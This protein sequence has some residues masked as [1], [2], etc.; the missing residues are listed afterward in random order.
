MNDLKNLNEIVRKNAVSYDNIK[1]H[2]KQRVTPSLENTVK[3][4]SSPGLF[5]VKHLVYITCKRMFLKR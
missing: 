1:S 5:R 2:K 4:T 3:V